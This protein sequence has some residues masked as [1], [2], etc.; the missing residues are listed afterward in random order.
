MSYFY[1]WLFLSAVDG[2]QRCMWGYEREMIPERP[3][4][5]AS[6]LIM[7]NQ[8]WEKL[9]SHQP[10]LSGCA[11]DTKGMHG[12]HTPAKH[13]RDVLSTTE[14]IREVSWHL[15]LLL[16]TGNAMKETWGDILVTLFYNSKRETEFQ[17]C[18]N[19]KQAV[20]HLLTIKPGNNCKQL[21]RLC[22]K[23][24]L[25]APVKCTKGPCSRLPLGWVQ[26]CSLL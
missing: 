23:I 25:A 6:D 21:A 17:F 8:G 20:A 16:S 11:R 12:L 19:M 13:N 18:A 3:T 2:A 7:M 1:H 9:S 4:D 15:L 24:H 26:W 10:C 5:R 14:V 22:D